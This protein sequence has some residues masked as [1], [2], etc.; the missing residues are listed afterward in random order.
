MDTKG[1]QEEMLNEIRELKDL[2]KQKN[3]LN[4]TLM[5]E[6]AQYKEETQ[7]LASELENEKGTG[8]KTEAE[9]KTRSE[10]PVMPHGRSISPSMTSRVELEIHEAS[11]EHEK[12]EMNFTIYY[13]TL[14]W[15]MSVSFYGTVIIGGILT[16]TPGITN[17][18]RETDGKKT[19]AELLTTSRQCLILLCA[20]SCL[21]C[22]RGFLAMHFL[23]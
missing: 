8:Q 19:H 9:L 14:A 17:F 18:S 3:S 13:R 10:S 6:L 11:H 2:L 5:A 20:C 22:L 7:K 21:P 23:W 15:I 16:M 12:P 1:T 4:K